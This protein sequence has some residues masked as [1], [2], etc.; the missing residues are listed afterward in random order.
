VVAAE[1]GRLATLA[2]FLERRCCAFLH[3]RL[4]VRP[5]E[6]GIWLEMTGPPG[7]PEFLAAEVV[8]EAPGSS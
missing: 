6:G 1:P 2:T 8:G 7:T 5:G 4:T 3:L